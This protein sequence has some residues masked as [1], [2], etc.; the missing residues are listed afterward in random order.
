MID[1]ELDGGQGDD[2]LLLRLCPLL[3]R[4]H[5]T[6]STRKPPSYTH[7]C[8]HYPETTNLSLLSFPTDKFAITIMSPP[9]AFLI[10]G[11]GELGSEVLKSLT[12][13]PSR[14][15]C[16][17]SLLLRPSTI[18]ST[19]P[20]K[21][22]EL[23]SY[24][25]AHINL[26]SGDV[27]N[28]TPSHLSSKL[29]HFDTVIGCTGMALPAGAQLKLSRAVLEAGVRR[30]FPWQFGIDYDAIG[31]ESAQDLFNEQLDVRELLRS[32]SKTKWV[33]VS[34]GMFMSFLFEPAFGVVNL[35][36]SKVEALGSWE[37]AL[38]VTAVEDIGRMVAELTLVGT[39]EQ[40]VVYVAGDTVSMRRLADVTEELVGE[41]PERN[42]KT[43]EQLERELAEVPHDVMRKYRVVFAAGIGVSWDKNETFNARKRIETVSME[44]WARKNMKIPPV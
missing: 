12:S 6:L 43:T 36:G 14:G 29:A 34:T 10:L 35:A 25:D 20:A 7:I 15:S 11:A 28:D 13:H 32:Q 38:T 40:G 23:Q 8:L 37:N 16:Q 19:N 24:K 18:S 27:A 31:R 21:Q 33:V 44:G 9:H 22:A 41:K 5:T 2:V 3:L 39:D 42:L 26:V 4:C 17:I 30:Y 1:P